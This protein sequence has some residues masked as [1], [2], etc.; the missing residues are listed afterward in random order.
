MS[1]MTAR[2]RIIN[3]IEGKPVDRIP[4][5]P[6]L[7]YFWENQPEH[8][9]Q[10]G[11]LEFLREIGADPLW[12]GA[13]CP[14]EQT[15]PGL[16]TRNYRDGDLDITEFITPVGSIR[17]GYTS[18]E[19][20][21]TAFLVEHPL[22]REE[23]FK[24]L[25]WM[26]ENAVVGMADQ[27]PVREHLDMD[28][29]AIGMLIPRGKTA[30]QALIEHY[31]GT[32]EMA[33]AVCDYPETVE[34]LIEV[35]VAND[36]KAARLA[37]ESGYDYFITWEDSSTTNYSPNQYKRY[38]E[39]EIRRFCEILRASGKS[40]IQHAC[41]HVKD[42][43]VPMKESGIKAIESVSPMPTGNVTLP[44]VREAMGPNAGIIGGIEPTMLLN[45]PMS[46]LETY[47]NEVI[48][49]CLGGP[50]VLSNSDSCPPGVDIEKF[51][52]ISRIVRSRPGGG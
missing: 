37:V 47:V 14:V 22:K 21:N 10:A 4:F 44:E 8:V 5:S 42:L 3:A 9:Q 48:D 46:E 38:I 30:F 49:S 33:Y 35:M 12:R 25:L 15:T 34:A 13:P 36:L 24:T 50:F 17:Q 39:P 23:D 29:L 18:S 45:L 31:V 1:D 6:F 7:A 20:G 27:A 52:L 32:E 19:R 28:G 43:L 51:K 41:G 16:E 11:Q 2:E 40:Y 26:E